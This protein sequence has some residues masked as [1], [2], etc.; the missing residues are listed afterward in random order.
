[1]R[2]LRRWFRTA[3]PVTGRVLLVDD[4]LT[5]GAT[6]WAAG[7]ALLDAGA[8]EVDYAVLGRASHTWLASRHRL[9]RIASR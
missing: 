1:M 5:T 3:R 7:N 9:G 8:T 6:M 2:G 4:V